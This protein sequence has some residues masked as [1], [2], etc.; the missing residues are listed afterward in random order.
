MEVFFNPYPGAAKNLKEGKAVVTL[1]ARALAKFRKDMRSGS[2]IGCSPA[3]N[4][5]FT[6]TNFVLIREENNGIIYNIK[7]VFRM[8]T[9]FE[10]EE[11][12]LLLET[13][14]KGRIIEKEELN[15]TEDWTILGIGAAAPVLE[16][17]QKRGAI[18]FTIPTEPFWCLDVI[19]FEGRQEM[20]HNLWGQEDV[21][22]VLEYCIN[23]IKNAH[24][25][26]RSR[27][28]AAFC[29]GALKGAP[30]GIYWEAFGIFSQMD[31][32]VERGFAVD[33]DLIKNVGNTEHGQLLELRCY[34]Y[35]LR[36]FF[37]H[38]KNGD[39]T[40]LVGGFYQKNKGNQ[41]RA[42]QDASNRIS[43]WDR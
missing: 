40:V 39:A 13:F 21:T 23:S 33:N 36:V 24:E 5:D 2:I 28:N 30:E 4:L 35:G 43:K 37:V 17:A 10:R 6:P 9:S 8:A 19:E 27:Y 16:I 15:C 18:A 31:K 26:F 22:L 32:A 11:L 38:I 14:S 20:L 29:E 12:R 41:M 3:E 1:A 7:D 34:E 42:I 25:R